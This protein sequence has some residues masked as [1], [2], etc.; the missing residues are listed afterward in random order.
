[1][2]F[3]FKNI[4]VS[5]IDRYIFFEF[6]APFIFSLG[7]FLAITVFGFVVFNLIDLMIKYGLGLSL[8]LKLFFYSIPEMLYYSIPMSVLLASVLSAGRL[9]R[10][11]EIIIL[12]NCGVN[13][14]RLFFPVFLF[15]VFLTTLSLFF[16]YFIV[17]KSNYELSKANFL[18]QTK[19]N[20]PIY[21]QNIFYKEFENYNLKRSFYAREF[22][23]STM[24]NPTVEEFENNNLTK[25]IHAQKAQ[26]KNNNWEFYEGFVYNLEKGEI[27]NYLKFSNY[28]FPFMQSLESLANEIRS[29]KEMNYK[30]LKEYIINLKKSGEKTANLEVQLYQKVSI[31]FVSIIFF[32]VGIPL[33]LS[34]KSK[35]SSFAYT[36]SLFFIFSY[37]IV[38]F[39]FTALGSIELVNPLL[40][41]WLPNILVIVGLYL[42]KLYKNKV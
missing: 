23:N 9:Y 24:F 22:I 20:M 34:N 1:M 25:I 7:L 28:S 30:E 31:P 29:P 36:F 13:N 41:A 8:V 11:N 42:V 32:I 3:K 16:N 14:K 19:R 40:A 2:S 33:G 21:K 27:K 17:S 38:L 35:N 6:L 4:S 15:V 18:A 12:Q 39:S 10:D 5:I 26:L 37:Y